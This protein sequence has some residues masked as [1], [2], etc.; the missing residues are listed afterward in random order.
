M[1]TISTN[2]IRDKVAFVEGGEKLVLTVDVDPFGIVGQMNGVV[3]DLKKLNDSSSPDEVMRLSV[4]LGNRMF[5]EEQTK[6]LV[7]F[8]HGDEKQLFS[9]L[10]RYFIE[11]LNKLIVDAQKKIGRKKLFGR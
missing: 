10:T 11:R 9:V 8:Y 1:Y 2:H 3:E 5:G 4:E 6:K 7:E